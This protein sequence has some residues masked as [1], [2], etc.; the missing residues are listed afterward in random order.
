MEE[1]A[2]CTLHTEYECPPESAACKKVIFHCKDCQCE[3]KL[4]V[5]CLTVSWTEACD[6][7]PLFKSLEN[8]SGEIIGVS[9]KVYDLK[10]DHIEYDTLHRFV[11]FLNLSQNREFPPY[12]QGVHNL[13]TLKLTSKENKKFS[14][15]TFCEIKN[16]FL[17]ALFLDSFNVARLCA[18]YISKDY[19]HGKSIESIQETF[20]L[21]KNSE[22]S[23]L[24]LDVID[25][26]GL[27]FNPEKEE[28][29][30]MNS[31]GDLL[32]FNGRICSGACELEY[33]TQQWASRF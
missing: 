21:T 6:I 18:V 19:I 13:E 30:V 31:H 10:L 8:D 9:G 17:A 7:C 22:P 27:C 14:L 32:N 25:K 3:H 28:L 1:A 2:A 24:Y 26:Y 33:E 29:S 11:D 16:L 20:N 4:T 5:N 12:P 23:H 15:L